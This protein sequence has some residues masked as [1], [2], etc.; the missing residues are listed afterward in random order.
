MEVRNIRQR[1]KIIRLDSLLVTIN[2]FNLD[3]PFR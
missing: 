3:L 1:E 2:L